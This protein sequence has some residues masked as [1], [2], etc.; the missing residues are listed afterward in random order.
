MCWQGALVNRGDSIKRR[1]RRQCDDSSPMKSS[2]RSP[3]AASYIS[4]TRR[5]DPATD[6][7]ETQSGRPVRVLVLGDDEVGKTALLQQF[8]TS[9]YMAAAVQTHFGTKPSKLDVDCF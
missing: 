1:R 8:M 4:D 5:T 9:V 2:S 7:T 6:A 3:D